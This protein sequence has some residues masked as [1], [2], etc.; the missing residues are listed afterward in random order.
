MWTAGACRI[1]SKCEVL[2]GRLP[3]RFTWRRARSSK[4]IAALP[5]S[6][7]TAP[8]MA[9]TRGYRHK[10]LQVGYA[11][12]GAAAFTIIGI[13]R[14]GCVQPPLRHRITAL[15]RLPEILIVQGRPTCSR[16]DNRERGQKPRQKRRQT[17]GR[18][19][20]DDM[21]VDAVLWFI[22]AG[23][24]AFLGYGCVRTARR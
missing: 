7:I 9:K 22:L 18:T 10:R 19:E 1:V 13:C 15:S 5:R 4:H 12:F 23:M 17:T 2:L 6:R 14:G 11:P 8:E 3:Q 24:V 20:E 16:V 21:A